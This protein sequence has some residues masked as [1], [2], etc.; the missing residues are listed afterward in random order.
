[1]LHK[2]SYIDILHV[3]V[4]VGVEFFLPLHTSH[5]NAPSSSTQFLP[6]TTELEKEIR[7]TKIKYGLT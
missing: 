2:F 7:Q 6:T 3:Y 4:F 5:K 1:M